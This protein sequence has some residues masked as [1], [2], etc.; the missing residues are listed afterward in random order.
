MGS[1]SN[2]VSTT[3]QQGYTPNAPVGAAGT[4][5]ITQAQQLAQSPFSMPTAPVAGFNQ[6]QQQ[7]FDATQNMQ[8]M[9][10]PYMQQGANYLNQSAQPITAQQVASYYNP[11]AANVTGQMQNIFGQQQR[12]TTG[13]LT[14]AAGGVGA[15][16]I[17][18]GQSELARSE[19]R[20]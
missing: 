19:E 18:V 6:T 10:Q 13:Q 17:A 4:Q 8:G 16:R 3:S 14:Q 1:K 15:D 5:A 20:R 11:M 9:A 2:Q 7:A 12:N